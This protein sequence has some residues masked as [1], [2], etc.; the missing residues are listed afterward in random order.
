MQP[1]LN[2]SCPAVSH[3]WSQGQTG[4]STLTRVAQRTCS[5]MRFSPRRI[6]RLENSTPMV[7]C[8]W[9]LTANGNGHHDQRR[10]RASA[11]DAGCVQVLCTNWCRRHD[12]PVAASPAGSTQFSIRTRLYGAP[13]YR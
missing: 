6:V 4:V 9:S 12:L 2:L 11:Q 5:L 13:T 3:S 7:C 1:D 10:R 8:E